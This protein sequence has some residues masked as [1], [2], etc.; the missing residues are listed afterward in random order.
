MG[1]RPG[2]R[3]GVAAKVRPLPLEYR[4]HVEPAFHP[5]LQ[6]RLDEWLSDVAPAGL[7]EHADE[8]LAS[9]L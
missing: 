1:S 6:D 8:A 5:E 2:F 7:G 4:D 3:R 9:R